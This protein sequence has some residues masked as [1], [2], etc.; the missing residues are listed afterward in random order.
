M[1]KSLRLLVLAMLLGGCA[2]LDTTLPGEPEFARIQDGMT[3]EQTLKALGKPFETMRFPLSGNE[4]WDYHYQDSWGY[5]AGFSVI[6][7]PGGLVV[8]RVTQRLNDG[9]D[10]GT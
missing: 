7:G 1:M 3:R 5:M 10:H 2:T 8:G 4:S 6:F 9:G